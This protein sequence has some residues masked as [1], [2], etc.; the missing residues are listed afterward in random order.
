MKDENNSKS[1]KKWLL[2]NKIILSVQHFHE[3]V[4]ILLEELF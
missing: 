4:I 1:S 2:I 3:P